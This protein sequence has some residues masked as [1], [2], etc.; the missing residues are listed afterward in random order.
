[1]KVSPQV[2]LG[3][4][5]VLGSPPNLNHP[6]GAAAHNSHF[7][8]G[9]SVDGFLERWRGHVLTE[10]A[11]ETYAFAVAA[12]ILGTLAGILVRAFYET[13]FQ[14]P[15]Q[16]GVVRQWLRRRL[17]AI[18][19]ATNEPNGGQGPRKGISREVSEL[20]TEFVSGPTGA[21]P[22]WSEREA[23]YSI[24]Y[25]QLCGQ[26]STVLN[27][28]AREPVK[29]KAKLLPFVPAAILEDLSKTPDANT[30]HDALAFRLERAVDELQM[31]LRRRRTL[32]DYVMMFAVSVVGFLLVNPRFQLLGTPVY[33]GLIVSATLVGS[34]TKRVLEKVLP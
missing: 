29:Q 34:I 4:P 23:F 24:S 10:L 33:A 8:T 27:T 32:S 13:G 7:V 15:L 18:D 9:F 25:E 3:H 5:P 11:S 17:E 28:L 30:A 21:F 16:R 26:I 12:V 31:R 6:I 14:I 2:F 19:P 22:T 1:M 20:E